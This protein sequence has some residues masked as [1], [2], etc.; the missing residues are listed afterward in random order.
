MLVSQLVAAYPQ[1]ASFASLEEGFWGEQAPEHPDA[2]IKVAVARLRKT[3]GEDLIRHTAAGYQLVDASDS[4]DRTVFLERVAAARE[5]AESG[6]LG[7]SL[8]AAQGAL[9]CWRG[10]PFA[11]VADGRSLQPTIRDLDEARYEVQDL[12]VDVLLTLGRVDLAAAEASRNTSDSPLRERRWEQ[13]MIALHLAGRNVEALRV[14]QQYRS[15]LDEE[16][17]LEPGDSLRRLE[18]EIVAGRS[19]VSWLRYQPTVGRGSPPIT[20]VADVSGGDAGGVMPV[21]GTSLIERSAPL[22]TLSSAMD[23]SR[24]AVITGPPGVGKTRLA[25]TWVGGAGVEV[26][27]VDLS[28]ESIATVRDSIAAALRVSSIEGG[29]G[30]PLAHRLARRELVLVLDSAE[31]VAAEVAEISRRMLAEHARLRVLITSRLVPGPNGAAILHLE[32]MSVDESR[33]LVRARVDDRL[34]TDSEIEAVVE[35]ADGLPLALEL[36]ARAFVSGVGSGSVHASGLIAPSALDGLTSGDRALFVPL[37]ALRGSFDVEAAA[38]VADRTA[39]E[40]TAA[41]ERL[42]AASLVTAW[43]T[44]HQVRFRLLEPVRQ[45]A[46]TIA[47][48]A[49]TMDAAR[50]RHLEFYAASAVERAAGLRDTREERTVAAFE[51]DAAQ[52]RTASRFAGETGDVDRASMLASAWWWMTLR[53]LSHRDYVLPAEAMDLP[54]F[55]DSPWALDVLGAATMAEWARGRTLQSI[56]AGE[57]AI[58]MAES[59]RVATPFDARFGLIASYSFR[60]RDDEAHHQMVTLIREAREQQAWYYLSGAQAQI[61]IAFAI[62]GFPDEAEHQTITAIE[63]AERSENSS[64]IAFARH[65]RALS[66]AERDPNGALSEAYESIR[67]STRVENRWVAG[68]TTATIANLYRRLGRFEEAAL[69][70]DGLIEHWLA[71]DMEPQFVQTVQE[72]ALLMSEI[73]DDDGVRLALTIANERR[74]ANPSLS[75]DTSA[76]ADLRRRVPAPMPDQPEAALVHELRALLRGLRGS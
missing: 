33:E 15:M 59:R 20:D 54:G 28:V 46:E 74:I 3:L 16:L 8:E 7:E 23:L 47:E 40:A 41:L 49:G 69:K 66:L 76:L 31:D 60:G 75:S 18:A 5:S 57:A 38:H 21:F 26:V 12:I 51:L 24:C 65:A 52:V 48:R 67:L 73:G 4:V 17:G 68:W 2:A 27:W 6:R 44:A 39:G 19:P 11:G 35:L 13:L 56:D 36:G 50:R 71:S 61:G 34:I 10:E 64:T 25:H 32:P 29:S 14:F 9:E 37:A 63:S 53:S 1:P 42:V 58:A 55:D 62:S 70:L 45:L 43:P 30:S 72:A 22:D